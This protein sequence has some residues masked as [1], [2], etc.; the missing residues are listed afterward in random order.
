MFKVE[1]LQSALDELTNLWMQADTTQR[2]DITAASQVIEKRL[3]DNPASEGESRS[4]DR[5]ITF[6]PPLAVRFQIEK[7]GPD[8]D[9]FARADVRSPETIKNGIRN[10]RFLHITFGEMPRLPSTLR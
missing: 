10:Y 7:D 2:K 6:I 5:R 9:R 3:R 4:E 8:R 1:W